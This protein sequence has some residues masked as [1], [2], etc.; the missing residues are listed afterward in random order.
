MPQG[1]KK[2]VYVI[3]VYRNTVRIDHTDPDRPRQW[4]KI[5]E[6]RHV[7][8]AVCVHERT[9]LLRYKRIDLTA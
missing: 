6:R 2:V 8:D 9:F 1:F 5:L 7:L 3:D 4:G